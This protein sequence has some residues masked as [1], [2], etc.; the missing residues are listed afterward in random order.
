[1]KRATKTNTKGIKST[2]PPSKNAIILKEIEELYSTGEKYPT[3]PHH[4]QPGPKDPFAYVLTHPDTTRA[5]ARLCK[6]HNYDFRYEV[7]KALVSHI[8]KMA[9]RPNAREKYREEKVRTQDLHDRLMAEI[10]PEVEAVMQADEKSSPC[11]RNSE[12]SVKSITD[13]EFL[14]GLRILDD[15]LEPREC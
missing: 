11:S 15:G 13:A 9:K 2:A 3:L 14:S 12:R 4:T 7:G 8:K 5:F 10:W 6:T 1:M